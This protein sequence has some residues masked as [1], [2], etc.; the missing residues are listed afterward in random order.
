MHN[1]GKRNNIGGIIRSA[2]AF[3]I[4]KVFYVGKQDSNCKKMKVMKDF[5]FFGN[6]GTLKK[7]DFHNFSS[8]KEAKEYFK[9]NKIFV[10]GV[11]IGEG[12]QPIQSQ[13]F[14]GNTA[15]FLGN[16][17]TGLLPMHR[18]I[19]DH[20]VYIPQYTDKTASLNVGVAA[21]IVFHHFASKFVLK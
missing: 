9:E 21:G 2:C 16:E 18:E 20:F 17:G 11:E 15:F 3:N 13:P 10:C 12:S 6:K 14:K 4:S 5:M 7:M 19:C 1:I 8:L